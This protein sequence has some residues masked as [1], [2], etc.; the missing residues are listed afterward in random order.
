MDQR[1]RHERRA[2]FRLQYP[3]AER[4][5]VQSGDR[6]YEVLDIS[7]G[8]AR[9]KL[10]TGG[11]AAVHQDQPFAGVLR[12][13]D[14]E[15]VSIEGVV[16]RSDRIAM[17]VRLSSGVSAKRMVADQIRLRKRYP[18]FFDTIEGGS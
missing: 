1:P 17:V 13:Q 7:E 6:D 3:L 2:H 8:G 10:L 15:T 4:P 12:F 11:H 16:L 5:T 18:L 9:M 14:G